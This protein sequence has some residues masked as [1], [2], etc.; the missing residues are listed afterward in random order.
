LTYTSERS[1]EIPSSAKVSGAIT[2]KLPEDKQTSLAEQIL[3]TI[4]SKFTIFLMAFVIG[5]ALVYL[6][7]PTVVALSG[8]IRADLAR[9]AAW[10]AALLFGL[11]VAAIIVCFTF[12]GLPA[13]LMALALWGMA[14]YLAQIP[15][16]LLIGQ[17]VMRRNFAAMSRKR[18]LGAMAAGLGIL[19]VISA[20]PYVDFW[21]GLV[22]VL[23]GMGSVIS[24][25]IMRKKVAAGS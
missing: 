25:V 19:A 3:G 24:G 2:R 5:L 18:T 1:A 16:G 6:A 11:P 9:S 14:I 8:A 17:L 22:V 15:V 4:R 7:R 10:G 12:I 21:F 23:F 20:V 13:G